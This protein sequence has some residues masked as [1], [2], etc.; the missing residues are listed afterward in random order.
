MG[1]RMTNTGVTK[2][3]ECDLAIAN[4]FSQL[5]EAMSRTISSSGLL[6]WRSAGTATGSILLHGCS[7]VP[8]KM[9]ND[10]LAA[11]DLN[12][13]CMKDVKMNPID[14]CVWFATLV[15]EA[16]EFYVSVFPDSKV[17]SVIRSSLDSHS[18]RTGDATLAKFR[19]HVW[20][21]LQITRNHRPVVR[22]VVYT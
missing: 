18:D 7:F 19:R 11:V 6:W 8:M 15:H 2:R 13:C 22:L 5:N 16:A 3:I 20:R 17:D 10:R 1:Y 4:C 21:S 12:P 14:S 9:D